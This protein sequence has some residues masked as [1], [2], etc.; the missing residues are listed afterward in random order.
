M[1]GEEVLKSLKAFVVDGASGDGMWKE[2]QKGQDLLCWRCRKAHWMARLQAGQANKKQD[3]GKH[4][5][6]CS[7]CDMPRDK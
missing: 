7:S 3:P 5:M 6:Y 2:L 1:K 4:M